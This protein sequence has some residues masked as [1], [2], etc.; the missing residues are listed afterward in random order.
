[1]SSIQKLRARAGR[2]RD[3][4][5]GIG[6]VAADGC[7]VGGRG[8]ETARDR[9][10]LAARHAGK[11][12]Q[13]ASG[14]IESR[15]EQV[16]HG[17]LT[18]ICTA[19]KFSSSGSVTRIMLPGSARTEPDAVAAQGTDQVGEIANLDRGLGLALDIGG[20]ANPRCRQARSGAARRRSSAG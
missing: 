6:P 5:I 16:A 1:M 19:V 2:N 13:P 20:K 14:V 15:G 11:H 4:A 18:G 7:G 9:R 3:V 12:R 17:S 10:R 8:M